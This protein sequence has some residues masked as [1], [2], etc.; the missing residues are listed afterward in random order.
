M[1][2]PRHEADTQA[3]QAEIP[4]EKRERIDKIA[5]AITDFIRTKVD[6]VF[7]DNEKKGEFFESGTTSVLISPPELP[8]HQDDLTISNKY[9]VT[10][11]DSESSEK[12]AEVRNEGK[13]YN[14]LRKYVDFALVDYPDIESLE[15]Y[16]LEFTISSTA[17]TAEGAPNRYGKSMRLDA[18]PGYPKEEAKGKKP[19]AKTKK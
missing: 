18:V 16:Q 6:G 15:D 4:T 7:F 9:I 19:A 3:L 12:N 2:T 1:T 11:G 8:A 5:Q 10:R 13:F 14:G 17:S